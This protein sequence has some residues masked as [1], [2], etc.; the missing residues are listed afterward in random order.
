MLFKYLTVFI[1]C[2]C[3]LWPLGGSKQPF[4]STL[5]PRGAAEEEVTLQVYEVSGFS[6]G[7]SGC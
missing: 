4:M 3:T 2:N 5:A 7:V 1:M 6:T